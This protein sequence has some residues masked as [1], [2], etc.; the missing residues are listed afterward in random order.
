MSTSHANEL[1]IFLQNAPGEQA[2][3]ITHLY[4]SWSYSWQYPAATWYAELYQEQI[5]EAVQPSP[6]FSMGFD[7]M[8][9]EQVV[10]LCSAA[11]WDPVQF[12]QMVMALRPIPQL[13]WK[14]FFTFSWHWRIVA[15]QAFWL[16]L[17]LVAAAVTG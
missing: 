4:K 16:A 3:D 7:E 12:G 6:L 1:R 11:G 14:Q 5:R 13:D 15:R 17:A 2:Q 8:E 10:N 9:R